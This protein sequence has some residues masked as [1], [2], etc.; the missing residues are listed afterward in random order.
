MIYPLIL[1]SKN[2]LL[3]PRKYKSYIIFFVRFC[4][5]CWKKNWHID[6]CCRII[7]F[8]CFFFFLRKTYSSWGRVEIFWWC[9]FARQQF[10]VTYLRITACKAFS[11][12]K[13]L[14]P[15]TTLWL[16]LWVRQAVFKLDSG[17]L[18]RRE[19]LTLSGC[20]YWNYIEHCHEE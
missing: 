12:T 3:T 9:L 13:C 1:L 10:W 2:F 8:A 4:Y 11:W 15:I 20:W 14:S 7:F 5:C 19:K 17:I 18:Q 16:N 6:L